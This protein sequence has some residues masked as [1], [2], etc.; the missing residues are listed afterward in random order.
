[1]IY[2]AHAG[3]NRNMAL[4]IQVNPNLPRTRGDKPPAEDADKTAQA[5]TPAH[6]GINRWESARRERFPYLPRTRGDK[7]KRQLGNIDKYGSTPHTRG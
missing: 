4:P 3:I 2:P 7:P 6:A 1:M 5:S